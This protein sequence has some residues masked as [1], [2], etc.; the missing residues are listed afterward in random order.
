MIILFKSILILRKAAF[1]ITNLELCVSSYASRADAAILK[2]QALSP[3]PASGM[4]MDGSV[5]QITLIAVGGAVAGGIFAWSIRSVLAR[6]RFRELATAAQAK[7]DEIAAQGNKYANAYSRS[8]AKIRDLK[9]ADARRSARLNSALK[10][11]KLLARNVRKLQTERENTKAKL[12]NIQGAML[13]LKEQTRVL[14]TEFEK[15]RDFYKRELLK[16]LQKRKDLEAELVDA[17]AE[18]EAFSRAV[19]SS[20]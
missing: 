14:Q 7:L 1:S 19:E 8:R 12:S 15:S 11:A 6:R 3:L 9:A 16:S 20:S 18:Q 4:G 10:K 13:S 5:I 17:R 2:R